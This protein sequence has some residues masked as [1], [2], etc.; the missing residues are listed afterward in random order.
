M[1][2]LPSGAVATALGGRVPAPLLFVVGGASMYV[3]AAL[4]VGLFDPV[5]P[6]GVAVVRVF[7]AGLVLLAWRRPGRAAWRPDR[8]RRSVPFG[9]ATALMNAAFYEAIPRLPLGTAV[10]LEFCGPVAVAAALSRR[11]RD[12]GAVVLA[13]GGVVLIADVRWSG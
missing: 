5:S 10:A 9:L 3:G 6:P 13:A 12:V 8:L 1:R 11:P 7:G 2:R 4:A